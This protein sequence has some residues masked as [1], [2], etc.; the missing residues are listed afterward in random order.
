MRTSTVV[1]PSSTWPG[2]SWHGALVLATLLG[3]AAAGY[4]AGNAVGPLWTLLVLAPLAE[5]VVFRVGLQEWLLR[6]ARCRAATSIVVTAL[7]FG[8]AHVAVR[9]DMTA[10]AVALPA[11]ALGVLYARRRQVRACV[12]AH[13]LMNALWLLWNSIGPNGLPGV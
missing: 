10:F 2:A 1:L 4:S 5:E 12:I 3:A 8:L 7:G 9:G 11:V 6:R 13:A